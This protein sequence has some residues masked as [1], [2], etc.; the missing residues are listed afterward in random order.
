[1]S[2]CKTSW[3]DSPESIVVGRDSGEDVGEIAMD[4]SQNPNMLSFITEGDF[5]IAKAHWRN[6]FPVISRCIQTRGSKAEELGLLWDKLDM[7]LGTVLFSELEEMLQLEDAV[8]D[9][10]GVVG[11]ADGGHTD[12]AHDKA[13]LGELGSGQLLVVSQFVE[14]VTE[15]STLLNTK[16]VKNWSHEALVPLNK[17]Q[18]IGQPIC[19]VEETLTSGS[20]KEGI[21]DDDFRK[22]FIK[23]RLGIQQ[24]D[25]QRLLGRVNGE[26][27][28]FCEE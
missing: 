25:K 7:V 16:L 18:P 4:R 11:L 21:L 17:S 14:P 19:Q 5:L 13:K 8:T 15:D 20:S 2:S 10:A 24:Q 3:Q 12:V 27:D 22:Y 9:K 23:C 26:L 28:C 6:K 1:M